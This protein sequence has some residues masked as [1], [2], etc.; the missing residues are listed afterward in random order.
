MNLPPYA[1][2]PIISGE[3]ISLRPILTSDIPDIIEIS[4]YDSV[5]AKT[6]LQA[7]EMQ[8]K[9]NRD[10]DNGNA[11]HWGIAE[12]TTNFIIGTC[13]YYRGFDKETGELG[14]VLLP[15]FRGKGYMTAAMQLAIDFGLNNMGLKQIRAV[16]TKQNTNAIKLL[17]R[18]H[19][20]KISDLSYDEIE[21]ELQ[22][23]SYITNSIHPKK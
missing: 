23:K 7:T 15:Q 12:N 8:S 16:T 4:F 18:L 3:N 2:F 10:Y 1:I 14:C 19:F 13:G 20:I 22:T 6:V 11:I 5:Q 21:Y 17:E 9:I